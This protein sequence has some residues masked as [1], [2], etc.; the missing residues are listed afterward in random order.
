[1]N[2]SR[3]FFLALGCAITLMWATYAIVTMQKLHIE[4]EYVRRN[5]VAV[6]RN[7]GNLVKH[8]E[9]QAAINE[10]LMKLRAPKR[11]RWNKKK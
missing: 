1:M 2:S 5:Y 4:L 6:D 8:M 11:K 9:V 3:D 10:E 7:L